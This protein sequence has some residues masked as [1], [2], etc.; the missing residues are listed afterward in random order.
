MLFMAK[1]KAISVVGV[2][3]CLVGTSGLGIFKATAEES[4]P[5]TTGQIKDDELE[6]QQALFEKRKAHIGAIR[7]TLILAECEKAVQKAKAFF[8]LATLRYG[9]GQV[10]QFDVTM[11]EL[12]LNKRMISV[13]TTQQALE[14]AIQQS[15]ALGNN[16]PLKNMS[17]ENDSLFKPLSLNEEKAVLKD[18]SDSGVQKNVQKSLAALQ[19]LKKI[20]PIAGKSLEL[21]KNLVEATGKRFDRGMADSFEVANCEKELFEA[22]TEF[23]KYRLDYLLE[24]ARLELALGK[25]AQKYNFFDIA[26]KEL[27]DNLSTKGGPDAG[28]E[29]ELQLQKVEQALKKV[30]QASPTSNADIEMLK[31]RSKI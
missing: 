14:D 2:L 13:A 26:L 11:A 1:L 3:V 21:T 8:E 17:L 19:L 29:T 27:T 5:P 10:T 4:K 22:K 30:N 6:K 28:K 20:I 24:L 16:P 31:D 15:E 18:A 12:K 9:A 23:I 7:Q 25:S